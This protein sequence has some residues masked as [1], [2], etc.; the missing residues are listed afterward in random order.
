[1]F[2]QPIEVGDAETRAQSNLLTCKQIDRLKS[3]S[4]R[5]VDW[6]P[7]LLAARKYCEQTGLV[8]GVFRPLAVR[9][10]SQ[11]WV[12]RVLRR[13]VWY[14]LLLIVTMVLGLVFF[15]Y[16]SNPVYEDLRSDLR[17][18]SA[19]HYV[20]QT[21]PVA[22][23]MPTLVVAIVLGAIGLLWSVATNGR[24]LASNLSRSERD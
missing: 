21:D 2:G 22:W 9:L 1:L 24:Q 3:D 19:A 18:L 12:D 11:R 6:P 16:Y 15:F 8:S 7:R 5:D 20:P 10:D 14:L 17:Y 4:L 13:T 23:M